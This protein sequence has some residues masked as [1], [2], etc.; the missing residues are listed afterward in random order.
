MK[1]FGGL[2]SVSLITVSTFGPLSAAA[3]PASPTPRGYIIEVQDETAA[4]SMSGK[5]FHIGDRH[6]VEVEQPSI[7]SPGENATVIGIEPVM[8]RRMT[9]TPDDTHFG[10]QWHHFESNDIDIDSTNAWDQITG[11]EIVVAVID[12]GVDVDHEDLADNIWVNTGEVAGNNIDDDGNGFIDDTQGWDFVNDDND[13]TPAPNN[14]DDDGDTSIDA[15]V[16][17]GT[18]VAGLVGAE[19]NNNTGV[20]GV[21]WEI[22]I[23]PLRSLDDEGIGT[24]PDIAEAMEYAVDNGADIINLS[25][26]AY[27]NSSTLQAGVDYALNNDVVVVA[28]AGNDGLDLASDAFYPAC[29]EGVIGVAATNVA[30]QAASFSNFGGDCINL[31]APGSS[32]FSTLYTDDPDHGF[33]A[34]YGYLSGTS[35]ATP[36]V[37]GAAA[38]VKASNPTLNRQE[39]ADALTNSTDDVGLGADYGTG[40][41]NVANALEAATSLP[42]ISVYTDSD[43]VTELT[44]EERTAEARPY[45]SWTTGG[46]ADGVGG[47][48]VSFGTDENVDP[49]N[50]GT[51]T[52]EQHFSPS[53]LSGNE[54]T[55]YLRLKLQDSQGNITAS[56]AQFIYVF[57]GKVKKPTAIGIDLTSRGLKV[58]WTA[59]EDEHVEGYLVRR[60]VHNKNNFETVAEVTP[61][62]SS[63]TDTAALDDTNYDYKVRAFDDLGNVKNSKIK[64]KKYHAIEMVVVGAGV[65]SDPYIDV[66]NP[67]TQEFETSFLAYSTAVQQG[68]EV[69]VGDI[70]GDGVDEIVTGTGEGAA[71]QV[72]VFEADGSQISTFYAY[73]SHLRTGVRVATADTNKDGIDEIVTVPG[74]GAIPQVKRFNK[75]GKLLSPGFSALDGKF[76]GG[77]FVAGVDFDDDGKDELAI[78]AGPGGG[79]QVTV[80]DPDTGTVEANF[81]AYD[82]HTFKGGIRVAAADTDNAAGEEIVTVPVLGTSHTQMFA[83]EPGKVKQLNPG[84]FAFPS[85]ETYGFAIATLDMDQTG[86]DELALARGGEVQSE[87]RIYNKSGTSVQDSFFT[88]SDTGATVAGGFFQF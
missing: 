43:Q 87:V 85:S 31:A 54:A 27:G 56:S 28:A 30:D 2:V 32:I 76:T 86:T 46:D 10:L 8:T 13:P 5:P 73:D 44:A 50:A 22:E 61:S 34:D 29:S 15:G 9:A 66:Y 16:T 68:I 78:G 52:T 88:L 20:A 26:G 11:G 80:H 3:Q 36:I 48:W 49:S 38:L 18:H 75:N 19:G 84:F 40:R 53:S 64:H 6:F 17:H 24:D 35:M 23:M 63:Y 65:G 21:A 1:Y 67:R 42:S 45:F 39:I 71:P 7:Q 81:F 12:S 33:T 59:V 4:K 37:T 58:S 55:Y 72:R 69:A 14:I 41:L 74:P 25:L 62:R 51:F 57:D 79:A 82:Q 77:A 60:S 47:Y 83:R 70:D